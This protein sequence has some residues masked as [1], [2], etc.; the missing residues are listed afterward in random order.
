M[1]P[2]SLVYL[3]MTQSKVLP[4]FKGEGS[5]KG[6]CDIQGLLRVKSSSIL[7]MEAIRCSE[8]SINFYQTTQCHIPDDGNL[9]SHCSEDPKSC[10]LPVICKKRGTTHKIS[11]LQEKQDASSNL[12]MT[13]ALTGRISCTYIGYSGTWS[14]HLCIYHR[15]SQVEGF[16]THNLISSGAVSIPVQNRGNMKKVFISEMPHY[17]QRQNF[18]T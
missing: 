10:L 4:V 18:R 11:V 12:H 9:N 2:W 3:L 1:T 5:T 14:C 16:A 17:S 6:I 15:G 7:K 8:T 13:N